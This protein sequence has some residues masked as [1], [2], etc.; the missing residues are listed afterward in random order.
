MIVNSEIKS[1]ATCVTKALLLSDDDYL[2]HIIELWRIGNLIY[3]QVW[4]TE[5]HIFG[6][7]ESQTDHLP[8]NNVRGRCSEA[9]LAKVDTEIAVY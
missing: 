8:T 2:D 7:I 6:L 1:H 5:F 9:W 4:Y 3:G